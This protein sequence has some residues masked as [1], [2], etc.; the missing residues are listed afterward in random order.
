MSLLHRL[1]TTQYA[2]EAIAN[3][4]LLSESDV[5][6]GTFSSNLGRLAFELMG[7]RSRWAQAAQLPST[8][9]SPIAVSLDLA[10][11]AYP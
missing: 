1:N 8:Q 6:V 5:F 10:W 9:P 11:Y 4:W 3:V 7:S 2:L